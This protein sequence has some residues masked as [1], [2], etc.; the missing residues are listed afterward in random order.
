MKKTNKIVATT[1]I[2]SGLIYATAMLL[3][4]FVS[5]QKIMWGIS[6]IVGLSLLEMI[7]IARFLNPLIP[8]EKK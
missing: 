5:D 4:L 1:Y 6:F 3:T 7:L 8:K 2:V